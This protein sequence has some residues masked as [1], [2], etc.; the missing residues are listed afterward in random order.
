MFSGMLANAVR[1]APGECP[2][3]VIISTLHQWPSRRSVGGL[4]GPTLC[5]WLCSV[6]GH[7]ECSGC[8]TAP[9]GLK[10]FAEVGGRL[11]H[12]I[13]PQEMPSPE[14]HEQE[15]SDHTSIFNTWSYPWCRGL[16]EI[17]GGPY[18]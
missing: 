11:A 16:S 15:E 18:P 17:S 9:G 5:R 2:R 6:Q 3:S 10:Q 1:R 14:Y 8:H 12:G 13:P 4:C 7:Q